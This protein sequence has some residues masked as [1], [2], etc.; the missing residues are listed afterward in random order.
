MPTALKVSRGQIVA[1]GL[2]LRCPNCGSRSLFEAG[3]PLRLNR[4][5]PNCQLPF[6]R[7][8]GSFLGAIALNYGIT[9]VAFLMPVLVG[10][11]LSWYSGL[12]ASIVALI[13]SLLV[14]LLIYRPSRSWWLMNYYLVLP[15]H[16]PANQ[17]SDLDRE[18]GI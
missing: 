9:T 7:D 2:T 5:C 1:R 17:S 10:Y 15:Q 6:E 16:L 12:T 4:Q 3:R 11:L 13:G 18:P 14:P 8:E